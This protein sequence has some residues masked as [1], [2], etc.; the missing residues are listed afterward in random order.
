MIVS[1]DCFPGSQMPF[2]EPF[3]RSF[4]SASVRKHA[5]ALPGLYGVSNALECIYIG[6]TE[7]IQAALMSHL[8]ETGTD[9]RQH[10]PTGFVFEVC[11]QAR[12][13]RQ[14]RLVLEYEPACNR[15]GWKHHD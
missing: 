7:N 3:P 14:E 8:Q 13:E 12:R 11:D 10:R 6:E 9:M 2:C 15:H 5:P 4:T 1:T